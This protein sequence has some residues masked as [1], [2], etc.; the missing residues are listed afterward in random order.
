MIPETSVDWKAFEYK[1]SDNPQKAFENLTYYLFCHELNQKNGIFRYLNQPHI[2]TNP[3]PVG[4]KMIGFQ[5]KYYSDSVAMSSKEYE[6]IEA[7]KGAKRA[8]PD[9][10]TI[11]FYISHEFSPSSKKDIVKPSYQINIENIAR[12]LGIEIEWRWTSNIDAQL[13]QDRQLTI[14]RNV[15]F[16]VDSAVQKCCESLDKHKKDIFDHINTSVTYKENTIVLEHSELDLYS[17]LNSNNQI[18]I[19]D[20]DAGSGKSALIKQLMVKLSDDSVLLAFKSTDLDVDDKLEF[21][22]L[23]GTLTIDEVLDIYKEADYRVLYIDAAEKYFVLENQQIFEDIIQIFMNSDW[24]LIFTIRTAYKESFHNLLLNKV[25]IQSHHVNPISRDKLSELSS[26]YGFKLPR[27]KMLIDLI[28]AKFYLGL[29]LALDNLDNEEM[30][31]L[32]REAFEEKIWK[33]IIRNN[34]KRKNNMPTRRENVIT[35]ITMEMLQNES[36]LYVI[37]AV[38]D[39]EAL[40]ELEHAG[41]LIQ[42]DDTKKYCLSHDVFEELVVSHIFMEQY[43]CN[44]EGEQFFAEFRTSLRIRK[45]FRGWLSDFA[46]INEHQNIIFKI[47]DDKDVN[48]IWKDEVLLTVISTESLKDVYYKIASNMA[49]NNCEMLKKITFLINTC[50]RVAD[51]AEIY[52]NKGNLLP[53]RLS[54]PFGYAWEALFSFIADN[55][56]PICWDKELISLVIDVLDSWTKHSENAKTENTRIA[57]EIGVFL[58]EKIS[59]DEDLRYTIRSEQFEKLQDVL[60]NSAWMIK[61][62]LSCIFQIVIDGEND[63]EKNSF[64]YFEGNGRLNVSERYIDLAERAIS[65][66]YHFGNVPFAMPEVTMKLMKKLWMRHVDVPVYYSSNIESDFGLNEHLSNE[67]YPVSAFKTPILNLLQDNQKM[68][69]DFLLDLFNEAGDFYVNSYLNKNYGECFKIFIRVGDRQIEQI[70]SERLWKMY[71]GTHVG[72]HLL[73]SLLMGFEKW[74]LTVV[75][76]SESNIVVDYCQYVL[77]NSRNVMLTSVI[78][79]IAEAYP[80]KMFDIICDLLK[81]KEIFQLV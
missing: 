50:C 78:V 39:Y 1:Y 58:F 36:Y 12:N 61:E 10:T 66:I 24:K 2:E 48:R 42:T 7:V 17:F 27:D 71:R 65:D 57:G 15:F 41:I 14:C 13:M 6:L 3:I 70:A 31:A 8:Y 79:S 21:L 30:L 74:L 69:T 54:K 43:R 75:K 19:V 55:K 73:V 5:S 38:D 32:N 40:S 76:N 11:Y 67:Y 35:L 52:L 47:L 4:E 22:T 18:L 28:C 59:A 68:T 77:M 29:Y 72:P 44:I 80:E 64:F 51:H 45:L 16:Q 81:T 62:Y 37:K 49:E 26:T 56:N 20:G 60:F 53:F 25:K 63:Y 34:R 46:S 23:H 33:D 9:I